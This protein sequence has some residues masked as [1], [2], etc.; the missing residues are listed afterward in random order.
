VPAQQET[1]VVNSEDILTPQELATRLKVDVSW[2]YE[3]TRTRKQGSIPRLPVFRCG[4][5]I[6]FYWPDVSAWLLATRDG[7]KKTARH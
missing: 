4:K 2:I 5:Y 7:I 3:K 6:R 1:T